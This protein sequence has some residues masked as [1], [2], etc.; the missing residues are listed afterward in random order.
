MKNI[1]LHFVCTDLNFSRLYRLTAICRFA[2][3]NGVM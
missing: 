1:G 3:I 2:S